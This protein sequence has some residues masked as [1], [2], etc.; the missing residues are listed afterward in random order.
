MQPGFRGA[1]HANGY[2]SRSRYRQVD[3]SG[4]WHSGG[5]IVY[6]SVFAEEFRHAAGYI[7]RIGTWLRLTDGRRKLD[8]FSFFS[9]A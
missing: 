3:I 1:K 8:F 6:G 4:A 5:L 7:D 9:T 2:D